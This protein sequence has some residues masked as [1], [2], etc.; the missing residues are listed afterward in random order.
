M[1]FRSEGG[2]CQGCCLVSCQTMFFRE[3][4]WWMCGQFLSAVKMILLVQ[5][6]SRSFGSGA[7]WMGKRR[8]SFNTCLRRPTIIVR[9]RSALG[10]SCLARV[11]RGVE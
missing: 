2:A 11:A 6:G 4:P 3:L 7:K 5:I 9:E 10:K 1:H 8:P